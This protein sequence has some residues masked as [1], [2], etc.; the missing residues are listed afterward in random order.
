MGNSSKILTSMIIAALA[1]I[2]SPSVYA[3]QMRDT[4]TMGY[5]NP[6]GPGGRPSIEKQEQIRKRVEMIKLWR[7]T[8]ALKL[9]QETSAKLA[10]LLNSCEQQRGAIFRE[11]RETMQNLR[12]AV[13]VRK[14]DEEKLSPLLEKLEANHHASQELIEKEWK[15]VQD[16]LTTEQRARFV[17]FQQDF[18][19]DLHRMISGAREGRQGRGSAGPPNQ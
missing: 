4:D 18:R 6:A 11:R 12:A 7:L 5:E 14:P 19:R 1:C 17:I 13:N 10:A 8:E 9:D 2:A 16:I 15:G 3:Q